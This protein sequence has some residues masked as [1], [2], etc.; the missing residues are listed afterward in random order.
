MG[1]KDTEI[2]EARRRAEAFQKEQ[3][4][5]ETIDQEVSQSIYDPVMFIT[6]IPVEFSERPILDGAAKIR[7]PVDFELQSPEVIGQSYIGPFK[8]QYLLLNGY[9]PFHWCLLLRMAPSA[10]S[11]LRKCSR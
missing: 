3:T 7:M 6:K 4:A 5:Q 8:P 2:L 1:Y 9:L 11:R 10:M